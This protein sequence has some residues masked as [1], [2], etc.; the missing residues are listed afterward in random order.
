MNSETIDTI[1]KAKIGIEEL[2]KKFDSHVLQHDPVYPYLVL[3]ILVLLV[4]G[5]ILSQ[6]IIFI[7]YIRMRSEL[8]ALSQ[9]KQ[10]FF[11]F[12]KGEK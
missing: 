9:L 8:N 5:L 11:S 1:V 7:K 3:T 4:G 10:D 2:T 12:M 6:S